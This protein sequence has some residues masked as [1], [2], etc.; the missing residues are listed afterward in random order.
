MYFFFQIPSSI[1]ENRLLT[2]STV[3]S[4]V[5]PSFSINLL[6][7]NLSCII[8]FNLILFNIKFLYIYNLCIT[9]FN[10]FEVTIQ[11]IVFKIC[12]NLFIYEKFIYLNKSFENISFYFSTTS[13][14]GDTL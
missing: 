5:F 13:K 4:S 9:G 7:S 10:F 14:M 8:Y 1:F 6:F 11:F 3:Y 2:D 12:N